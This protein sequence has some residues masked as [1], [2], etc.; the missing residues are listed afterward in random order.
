MTGLWVGCM[1]L[2]GVNFIDNLVSW[3]WRGQHA[4]LTEAGEIIDHAHLMYD[5]SVSHGHDHDFVECD[6]LSSGR[7]RPPRTLMYSLYS[8]VYDDPF[9]VRDD[10]LDLFA[11]PFE[12]RV[13][14]F[15][16]LLKL[17]PP[18]PYGL[19][20]IVRDEVFCEVFWYL[21]ELTLVPDF[22]IDFESE[23]S[24]ERGRCCDVSSC[25]VYFLWLAEVGAACHEECSHSSS[26]NAI[27]CHGRIPGARQW[28]S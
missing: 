23:F 11:K 8:E 15:N 27:E 16:C 10:V 14:A 26:K 25:D 6:F 2:L 12:R 22:S 19:R 9:V 17:T 24:V 5:L 18:L 13:R 20:R 1:R 7:N 28:I 3:L 21:F 4:D